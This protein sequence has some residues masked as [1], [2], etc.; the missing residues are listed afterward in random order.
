MARPTRVW[1]YAYVP[2]GYTGD[3]TVAIVAQIERFAPGRAATHWRG[4]V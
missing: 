2:N 1:A 3:A 4:R